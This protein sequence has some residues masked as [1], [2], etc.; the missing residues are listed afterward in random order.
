M[1]GRRDVV[2]ERSASVRIA[3]QLDDLLDEVGFGADD[4]VSF[5]QRLQVLQTRLLVGVLRELEERPAT[6]VVNNRA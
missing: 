2:R 1:A 3:G 4:F 5:D 6:T